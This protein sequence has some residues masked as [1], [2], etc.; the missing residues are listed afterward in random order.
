ML[1]YLTRK[2]KILISLK[3]GLINKS[4]SFKELASINARLNLIQDIKRRY[5]SDIFI[6]LIDNTNYPLF[7]GIKHGIDN[8]YQINKKKHDW[9]LYAIN[10]SKMPENDTLILRESFLNKDTL[11]YESEKSVMG[12]I[13]NFYVIFSKKKYDGSHSYVANKW[14]GR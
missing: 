13:K 5:N 6:S 14:Q 3:N 4:H 9:Y 12:E 2:E 8:I 1:D 10:M 7:L 11:I